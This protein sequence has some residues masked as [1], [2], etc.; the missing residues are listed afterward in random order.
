MKIVYLVEDRQSRVVSSPVDRKAPVLKPTN[1]VRCS[2]EDHITHLVVSTY[3][4][5]IARCQCP[6]TPLELNSWSILLEFSI[7]PAATPV[8]CL[9]AI[10][11]KASSAQRPCDQ[12][13][14]RAT[15]SKL[16]NGSPWRA[17]SLKLR[18]H[19]GPSP[20]KTVS[21]VLDRSTTAVTPT[22]P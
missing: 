6:P 10:L 16:P 3:K 15:F 14:Y 1:P 7:C 5:A 8:S 19:Q 22:R 13:A 9:L 11:H 4:P 18:Y 12:V 21:N 17:S 20:V 2:S